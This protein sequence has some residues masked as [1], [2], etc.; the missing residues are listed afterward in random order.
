MEIGLP[1]G[2][3]TIIN[4]GGADPDRPE[5]ISGRPFHRFGAGRQNC[6]RADPKN[7]PGGPDRGPFLNRTCQG[8]P[9]KI[10]TKKVS[11]YDPISV[12]GIDPIQMGMLFEGGSIGWVTF[13]M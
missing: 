10:N 3:W 6:E 8:S 9:P 11:M 12:L 1:M 5:N 13:W 4:R 2:I 7:V